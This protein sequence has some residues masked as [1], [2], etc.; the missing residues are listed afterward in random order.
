MG[1]CCVPGCNSRSEHGIKV[2]SITEDRKIKWGHAIQPG[3]IPTTNSK[4]CEV[5]PI[6]Y[7]LYFNLKK[8]KCKKTHS[9]SVTPF[10]FQVKKNLTR[11]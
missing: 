9:E 6:Y 4:I 10:L 11:N 1:C 3:W 5:C 7:K 2:Y 8:Y